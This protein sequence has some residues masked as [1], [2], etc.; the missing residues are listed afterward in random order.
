MRSPSIALSSLLQAQLFGVEPFDPATMLGAAAL[1]VAIGLAAC[2]APARRA[3][4]I[5]PVEA[6]K[7]E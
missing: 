7:G 6:L 5:E 3:A 2:F 4:S 1:F